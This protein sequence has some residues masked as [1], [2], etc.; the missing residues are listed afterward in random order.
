[1]T[2]LAECAAERPRASG[3]HDSI[4]RKTDS[5][6]EVNDCKDGD[7][8]VDGASHLCVSHDDDDDQQVADETKHGSDTEHDRI[9]VLK[10]H[11]ACRL[12]WFCQK[13]CGVRHRRCDIIVDVSVVHSADNLGSTR[14]PRLTL[15]RSQTTR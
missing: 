14:S 7:E 4:E 11:F 1:M 3:V 8:R 15:Q 2:D 5:E 6:Q 12:R 10:Q 9:Q 13:E